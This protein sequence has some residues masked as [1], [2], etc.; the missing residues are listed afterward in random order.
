M[1]P[2]C[3]T[4][5]CQGHARPQGYTRAAFSPGTRFWG[6]RA[7]VLAG[8]TRVLGLACLRSP[9]VDRARCSVCLCRWGSYFSARHSAPAPAWIV[10]LALHNLFSLLLAALVQP[11]LSLLRVLLP[12]S[13]GCPPWFPSFLFI[14]PGPQA[15]F[16]Q[17]GAGHKALC[18]EL[19]G[20]IPGLLYTGPSGLSRTPP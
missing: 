2:P 3:V 15:S 11:N 6:C 10:G 1:S 14:V 20:C 17:Q 5:P 8:G 16:P 4:C 12:F 13:S 19:L 9:A 7:L 18:P